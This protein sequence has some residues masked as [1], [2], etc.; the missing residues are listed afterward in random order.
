MDHQYDNGLTQLDYRDF[1]RSLLRPMLRVK[2]PPIN[3]KPEPGIEEG[4]RVHA[5]HGSGD[6]WLMPE[7][8]TLLYQGLEGGDQ[9]PRIT[10]SPLKGVVQRHQR[11]S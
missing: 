4:Y 10:T 6:G 1:P 11:R 9:G 7:I 3:V 2:K 8:H 5:R